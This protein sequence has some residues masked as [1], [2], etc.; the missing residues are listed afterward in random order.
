MMPDLRQYLPVVPP[1]IQP[2]FTCMAAALALLGVV[3]WLLGSRFSR[4]LI[5]LGAVAIGAALG[6]RLPRWFGLSIGT[7]ATAVGGAL[8]FGVGG[9]ILHSGIVRVGLAFIMGIIAAAGAWLIDPPTGDWKLP[10][11]SS[12]VDLSQ[13]AQ[14]LWQA[15]PLQLR[16]TIPAAY[17]I[18]MAIG[19]IIGTLLPRIAVALFYSIVG[20]S[21]AASLGA[22]AASQ[23]YPQLLEYLPHERMAQLIVFSGFALGG[24]GLQWWLLPRPA[25][26]KR[27]SKNKE[28]AADFQPTKEMGSSPRNPIP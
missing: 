25:P 17:G 16:T 9:Y 14:Q 11:Y 26:R 2:A 5:T 28:T 20:L 10:A 6:L 4:S 13:Y 12:E 18:A 27:S 8:V 22:Y 1:E 19:A 3:L 7:W 15:L 21:L 23:Q 24:A